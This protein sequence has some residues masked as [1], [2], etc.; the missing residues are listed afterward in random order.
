MQL[1]LVHQPPETQGWKP[2]PE[3]S[4][5]GCMTGPNHLQYP[6]PLATGIGFRMGRYPRRPSED[7]T[8]SFAASTEDKA[9]YTLTVGKQLGHEPGA[10]RGHLKY[11]TGKPP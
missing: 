6:I 10:I 4:R 3:E 9:F 7:Q 2:Q 1:Q 8:R 11:L 5:A